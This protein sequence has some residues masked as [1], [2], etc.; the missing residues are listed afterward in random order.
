M[1][2]VRGDARLLEKTLHDRLV[3]DEVWM[4]ELDGDRARE[5]ALPP[6]ASEMD[7]AHSARRDA[8]EEHVSA[9]IDGSL[10]RFAHP[11]RS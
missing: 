7:G 6:H 1:L 2:H 9:E 4:E 11:L 8:C 5:P 3:G 10:S